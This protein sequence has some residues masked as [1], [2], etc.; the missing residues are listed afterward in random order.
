MKDYGTVEWEGKE[1]VIMQAAHITRRLGADGNGYI[2][3][4]DVY[5]AWAID[6]DEKDYDI[7]WQIVNP[8]AE[9]ESDCCNWDEFEVYKLY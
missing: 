4:C 5:K 3:E 2:I 7:V 9:D 6:E 8:D 1:L